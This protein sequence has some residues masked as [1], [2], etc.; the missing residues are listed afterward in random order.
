[1]LDGILKK[2]FGFKG[3]IT[4]DSHAVGYMMTHHNYT[5]TVVETAQKAL[6]AGV[7]LEIETT[8][9]WSLV[10]A[11]EQGAL[12]EKEIRDSVKKLFYIR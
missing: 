3:Y 2:E 10:D 7:N 4:S 11:Y 8:I 12:T 5:K 9:F 6:R 1:M